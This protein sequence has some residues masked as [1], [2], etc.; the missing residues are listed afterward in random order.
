MLMS[1][2][3]TD[4]RRTCGLFSL[5]SPPAIEW[6]PKGQIV[7]LV[8]VG[9]AERKPPFGPQSMLWAMPVTWLDFGD[10]W[11]MRESPI[12]Y[13]KLW[14]G[15]LMTLVADMELQDECFFNSYSWENKRYDFDGYCTC[16]L[17]NVRSSLARSK[18]GLTSS[19]VPIGLPLPNVQLALEKVRCVIHEESEW[20]GSAYQKKHVTYMCF[21]GWTTP[22]VACKNID[23]RMWSDLGWWYGCRPVLKKQQTHRGGLQHS[24]KQTLFDRRRRVRWT[25]MELVS[26]WWLGQRYTCLAA[27]VKSWKQQKKLKATKLW[28]HNV[29]WSTIQMFFLLHGGRVRFAGI[30]YD[31]PTYTHM[32]SAYR[33]IAVKQHVSSYVKP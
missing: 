4:V 32:R 16:Q 26:C 29:Q 28:S 3:R 14:F 30:Y 23:T 31:L 15:W 11:W 18:S 2:D 10:Y 13:W 21:L 12:N 24:K 27:G 33:L 20:R 9:R 6:G 22:D 8:L 7:R 5:F 25:S 17:H 19:S 1:H